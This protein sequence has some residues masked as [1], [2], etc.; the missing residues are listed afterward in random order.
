MLGGIDSALLGDSREGFLFKD[1]LLYVK[2]AIKK[3]A[4]AVVLR[5]PA[6][7]Y[8]QVKLWSLPCYLTKIPRIDPGLLE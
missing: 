6:K 8:P 4:G 3:P 5:Q 1:G 7:R 2:Q